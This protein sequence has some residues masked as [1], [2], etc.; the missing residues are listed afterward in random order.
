VR[1]L[2]VSSRVAFVVDGEDLVVTERQAAELV[3]RHREIGDWKSQPVGNTCSHSSKRVV[4][5]GSRF[6]K[7]P[8]SRSIFFSL[9]LIAEFFDFV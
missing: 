2:A 3:Q 5:A 6:C 9:V 4:F 1:D 7:P 8:R